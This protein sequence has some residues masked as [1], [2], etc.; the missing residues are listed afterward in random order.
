M[1]L[2]YDWL[3]VWQLRGSLVLLLRTG[4]HSDL[5]GR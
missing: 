4:T 1:H 5:F 2:E 3:L